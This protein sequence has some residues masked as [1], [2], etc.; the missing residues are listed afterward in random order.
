MH[1]LIIPSELFLTESDP[2]AGIF[3]FQQ[4]NALIKAGINVGILSVGFISRRYTLKRYFY[5]ETE[6]IN[7]IP[8]FRK[9]KKNSIFS[10]KNKGKREIL[11][12]YEMLIDLYCM[13]E[14]KYGKPDLIHAHNL[15]PAGVIAAKIAQTKNIPVIVT[16]H[17]SAYG[18]GL[19]SDESYAIIK[20]IIDNINGLTCVG[21][22]LKCTL[23]NSLNRNFEI[24]PNLV[25]PIFY[26][27]KFNNKVNEVFK[28][29]NVASLDENKNQQLI[30]K[31]F[32]ENYCNKKAELI[33][34]GEG[35]KLSYLKKLTSEF[36]V[37]KQVKF[38]G[39]ISREE[40]CSELINSNCFI[41]SSIYE[42]FGVVLIEALSCG[43]PVI[44]TRCGEAVNLINP[45]NGILV[46]VQNIEQMGKAMKF[47]E[48]NIS[49]YSPDKMRLDMRN[50]YSSDKFIERA[51]QIYKRYI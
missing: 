40:V 32:A 19:V 22:S 17:S 14:L 39:R 7:E 27:S 33:I 51:I 35:K 38:L 29:I 34:V 49:K 37:S 12:S 43:I 9:Y 47:V 16:E 26:Q 11:D 44:S 23:E 46:D 15:L 6:I 4:A 24:L 28:F 25:E 3:Q 41:L 2:L 13:Y 42:T 20:N 45:T 30:I 1:I 48:E 18:R 50:R 31:A 5:K 36:G 8:V 21:E 10:F